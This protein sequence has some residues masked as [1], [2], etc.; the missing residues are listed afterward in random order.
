MEGNMTYGQL[1]EKYNKDELSKEEYQ[2]LQ[3][4][5]DDFAEEF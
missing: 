2:K 5:K 3:K 1:K 4:E